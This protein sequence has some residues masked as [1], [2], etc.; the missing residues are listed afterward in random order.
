ML[1]IEK[2]IENGEVTFILEGRLDTASAPKLE[3]EVKQSASVANAMI[4]DF[5]KVEYISSAGLRVLL[6]ALKQMRGKGSL[7]VVHVNDLVREIFDVTGF[8]NML[9]IE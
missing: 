8:S 1:N 9:T 6:L 4:M 7:K 3:E 2:A 5:E